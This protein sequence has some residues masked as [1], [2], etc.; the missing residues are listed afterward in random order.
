MGDSC[1]PLHN[2]AIETESKVGTENWTVD[3]NLTLIEQ[4]SRPSKSLSMTSSTISGTSN[5]PFSC[6]AGKAAS[7]KGPFS[8]AFFDSCFMLLRCLQEARLTGRK[9]RPERQERF[10]S[11]IG[12]TVQPPCNKQRHE[13]KDTNRASTALKVLNDQV[14]P[15]SVDLGIR[16]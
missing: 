3:Y 15:Q 10:R 4:F 12:N 13:R 6:A 2:E 9:Q 5:S 16:A 7:D 1:F 11:Q 14:F 8:C